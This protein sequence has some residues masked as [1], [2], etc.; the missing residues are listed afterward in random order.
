MCKSDKM[1]CLF[2]PS[3]VI[4]L[5]QLNNPT[6]EVVSL[7]QCWSSKR[8]TTG[9]ACDDVIHKN[10]VMNHITTKSQHICHELLEVTSCFFKNFSISWFDLMLDSLKQILR[11]NSIR[12]SIL[13][14]D[15]CRSSG[16]FLSTFSRCCNKV[17]S[18][19]SKADLASATF[20]FCFSHVRR[21]CSISWNKWSFTRTY[22]QCF[23]HN[24]EFFDVFRHYFQHWMI[25]YCLK[26]TL[27]NN[28]FFLRPQFY[29]GKG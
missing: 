20:T 10:D 25:R 15:V 23:R 4:K 14:L 9:S 16:A 2:K 19:S 22:V 17:D 29:I 28:D 26:A 18:A 7:F 27:D 6:V 24:R 12:D 3:F 5:Q 11:V 1:R 13:D 8:W 21:M